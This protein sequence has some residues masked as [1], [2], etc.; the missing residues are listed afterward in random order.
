MPR[1]RVLVAYCTRSGS[2]AGVAARLAAGLRQHGDIA[3]VR[4][5]R[6]AP[7]PSD[8]DAIVLGSPVFDGRWMPEAE[9]YVHAYEAAL[10]MRQTWLFSVGTFGDTSRLLGF[11]AKREPTNI[12]ALRAAVRP[13]TY[14]VFA[15]AVDR[16]AW[17][18]WSRMFFH[19]LGGRFGDNRDWNVIDAWASEIAGQLRTTEAQG[20]IPRSTPQI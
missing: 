1:S 10:Q 12:D 7:D 19:A 13:R 2:T 17:P 6:H 4:E 8:Y 9:A 15:G 5:V 16:A 11:L 20:C 18:L 3:D 14:R